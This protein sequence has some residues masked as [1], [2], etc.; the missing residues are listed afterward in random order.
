[1]MPTGVMQQKETRLKAKLVLALMLVLASSGLMTGTA[2]ADTPPMTGYCPSGY[3]CVWWDSH[4]QGDRYQFGGDNDY[5]SAW[6][7]ANDDS[8]SYNHGTTGR[9]ASIYTGPNQTDT[10]VVCLS[11]GSFTGHHSPNDSGDSN[12]WPWSC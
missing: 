3:L 11:M 12:V 7:I 4:Y 1:M 10:R 6:A 9:K 2:T 5:W 8:S